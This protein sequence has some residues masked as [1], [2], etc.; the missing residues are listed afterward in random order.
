[1]THAHT[2]CGAW[3]CYT[4][5]RGRRAP[6]S[7]GGHLHTSACSAVEKCPPARAEGSIRRTSGIGGRAGE[8][9]DWELAQG[10]DGARG[11]RRLALR[12]HGGRTGGGVRL[13]T[14]Q[15]G[16]WVRS[17][18]D[19]QELGRSSGR[20]G[21]VGMGLRRTFAAAAGE[22]DGA[23]ERD[24]WWGRAAS[25][26]WVGR[27]WNARGRAGGSRSTGR[28]A[29][30]KHGGLVVGGVLQAGRW[31]ASGKHGGSSR[32]GCFRQAGCI[33][34]PRGAL[35]GRFAGWDQWRGW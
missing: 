19:G 7:Q 1:M 5:A 24:G 32:E 35:S 11:G 23:E 27:A 28:D 9:G 8:G 2:T 4:G 13:R 10:H 14:D 3:P 18:G 34:E 33:R 20:A 17:A 15:M 31:D 29:S 21:I 22:G 16:R 6:R 12:L 26:T 25:G 30:G